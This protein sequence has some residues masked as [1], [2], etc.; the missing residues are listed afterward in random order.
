MIKLG[1]VGAGHLGKIHVKCARQVDEIELIGFFDSDPEQA[2]NVSQE[3]DL[4]SFE[5]L[6]ELLKEVDAVDIV[7]PTLLHYEIAK[8]ALQS[9]KHVFV[10]KPITHTV[11]EAKKLVELADANRLKLQVGHVERFN[12]AYLSLKEIDLNPKFIESHRLAIFNPR[13][14]DVSVILD[15]MIHDLDIILSMVD[16]P[17]KNIHASGVAVVSDTPDISNARIEFENGCVANLTASR[18]SMKQ[19]RKMRIF[20]KDAYISVDFL[21]KETQ[22]IQ[23]HDDPKGHNIALELD[24]PVGPK[25]VSMSMPEI[26]EINAI[27]EELFS[28]ANSI[29]KD[30]PT[31]VSGEDG[32]RALKLAHDIID[33]ISEYQLS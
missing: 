11:E 14:T 23:M 15:L 29:E 10:E 18:M 9:G 22:I 6:E 33:A 28:F 31:V 24:T 8:Q 25:Y 30:L 3:F 21:D 27:R 13:G 20:R 5:T 16:A 1:I 2:K 19:M 12:P 26:S 7:T 32:Y 17:I 4:K